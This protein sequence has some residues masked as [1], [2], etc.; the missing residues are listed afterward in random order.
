MEWPVTFEEKATGTQP[1]GEVIWTFLSNYDFSVKNRLSGLIFCAFSCKLKIAMPQCFLEHKTG[2]M[3]GL[4]GEKLL[5]ITE[6]N[7][8]LWRL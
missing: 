3:P 5:N 6:R 1:L 4:W 7:D 2:K 8:I